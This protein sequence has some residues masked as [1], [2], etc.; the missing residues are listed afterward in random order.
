MIALEVSRNGKRLCVAGIG[1]NGVVCA[2]VDWMG[3][4]GRPGHPQLKVGG[5]YSDTRF[6]A[7]WVRRAFK[8]GDEITI[9]VVEV[10]EVDPPKEPPA[11]LAV[12]SSA[13]KPKPKRRRSNKS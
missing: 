11:P 3:R 7:N 2:I 13:A 8:V 5:L 10:D 12:P 6:H 1:D 9:R 4:P